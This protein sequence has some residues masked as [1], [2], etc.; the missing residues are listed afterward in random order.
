[1]YILSHCY[2]AIIY[3]SFMGL[4]FLCCNHAVAEEQSI[5]DRYIAVALQGDLSHAA[6][7]FADPAVEQGPPVVQELSQ[8]FHLRFMERTETLSPDTGDPL[9]NSIVSAYREYWTQALMG[10]AAPAQ[11]V[12]NLDAS[13]SAILAAADEADTTIEGTDTYQRI[14]HVLNQKGYGFLETSAPPLRD[15]FLWKN[16]EIR[17]YSVLLADR[18]EYVQVVFM[19]E[20]SSLGWKEYATLGLMSTT[21]WVENGQLYCVGWAYDRVSES[22][23]ISYLKHESRHL[24]DFDDF[25]GL[26]SSQLEYRAKLTELSFAS[27]TLHSLLDDFTQKSANNPDSPHAFANFRVTRKLYREL[28]DEPFPESGN[29][30]TNLSTQRINRTARSL[31]QKDSEILQAKKP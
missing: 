27:K 31:L 20:M 18:T 22:F 6:S 29:P 4:S 25:P 28:Y 15:L 3:F 10:D 5:F 19:T 1:M 11:A 24:A 9:V 14:G 12:Q 13:L 26:S 21:G 8:L 16:E 30:W 23:E 7:L 17:K 2:I